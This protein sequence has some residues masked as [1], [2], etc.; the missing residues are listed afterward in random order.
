MAT[1]LSESRPGL[2]TGVRSVSNIL[3]PLDGSGLSRIAVPVVRHLADIYKATP[4]LIYA[5]EQAQEPEKRLEQL[6]VGW[7]ELQ[8]A[9]VEQSSG[10]APEI[11]LGWAQTLEQSLIVMCTHTGHKREPDRF[12]SVTEAV[13]A[14]NP[15]RIILVAPEG[16]HEHFRIR[17]LV[18]CHEGTPSAT[19]ATGPAAELAHLSSADVIAAVVASPC[20]ECPE[21]LGSFPAPQYIDQP[22]HEWPNWAQEFSTRMLALGSAPASLKFEI[23]VSG[24]QPGSELTHLARKRNVDMMIMAVSGDWKRSRHRVARDVTNNSG[25]PVFFVRSDIRVG[26]QGVVKS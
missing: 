13:M 3:L 5:G 22:Q 6:G 21:E 11:I 7:R 24:G 19:V 15:E 25:C 18:L 23:V 2:Q 8:G 17:T 1:S 10:P 14:G 12:G 16:D 9:V 26:I 4:H 20:T